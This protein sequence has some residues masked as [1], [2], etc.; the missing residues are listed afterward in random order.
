MKRT[1]RAF[2]A[3]MVVSVTIHLAALYFFAVVVELDLGTV[4]P[5]VEFTYVGRSDP[6]TFPNGERPRESFMDSAPLINLP[7]RAYAEES[8][9]ST[10]EE[11]V[12]LPVL[13]EKVDMVRDYGRA[14]ERI[15]LNIPNRAEEVKKPI[16]LAVDEH[17]T[18][19]KGLEKKRITFD[20]PS[21]RYPEW[22]VSSGGE[23]EGKVRMSVNP[24]SVI[25]DVES[26]QADGSGR[27]GLKPSPYVRGW[28]PGQ[29]TDDDET[30]SIK[31]RLK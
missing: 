11:E 10:T 6:D 23:T 13:A 21:A 9:V 25:G 3:T 18:E 4:T 5:L 29:D 14:P 19:E 2:K 27:V 1:D 12:S 20:S 24:G 8:I 26:V 17:F 7:D 15:R 28:R 22:A 30:I 31:F 16:K